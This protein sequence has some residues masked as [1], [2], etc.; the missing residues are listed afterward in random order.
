MIEGESK[1]ELEKEINKIAEQIFFVE[2]TESIDYK[3]LSKKICT[4]IWKWCRICFRE[5][6]ICNSG[7]EIFYCIKRTLK[8]YDRNTDTSYMGYLSKCLYNEIQ[9]KKDRGSIEKPR[10][11]SKIDYIQAK[12]LVKIAEQLGKNPVNEKVQKWLA[13][14][15]H[16]TQSEVQDLIIKYYQ[17]EIVPEQINNSDE[18]ETVSIFE[19]AAV[20]NNYTTPEDVLLTEE[21]FSE[22][23]EIMEK[24]FDSCQ[25]RQKEYL[26]PFYYT[27]NS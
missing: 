6:I 20:K 1:T 7:K 19:T 21:N 23:L 17:S 24:T 10:M 12:R 5:E 11:C 3:N 15:I 16:L 2:D 8:K 13:K 4:P 9:Y 18:D 27:Q 26:P 25:K 22:V 14:E